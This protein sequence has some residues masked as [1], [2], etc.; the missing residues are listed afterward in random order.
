M[1]DTPASEARLARAPFMP[2]VRARFWRGDEWRMKEVR[3]EFRMLLVLRNRGWFELVLLHRKQLVWFVAE[4]AGVS[5]VSLTRWWLPRWF[6]FEGNHLGKQAWELG[7]IVVATTC[8]NSLGKWNRHLAIDDRGWVAPFGG[9]VFRKF[10]SRKGAE[11]CRRGV[12]RGNAEGLKRGKRIVGRVLGA[13]RTWGC[14]VRLHRFFRSGL[15]PH[16]ISRSQK[17]PDLPATQS[18]VA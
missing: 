5:L 17:A 8:I 16:Q 6:P 10:F 1:L 13:P 4:V 18:G 9:E 12:H 15:L 2:F 14:C 7:G 3:V 11:E